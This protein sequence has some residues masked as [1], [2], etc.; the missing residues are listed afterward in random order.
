MTSEHT[1]E[2]EQD[3]VQV[4]WQHPRHDLEQPILLVWP[5][6]LRENWAVEVLDDDRAK[7]VAREILVEVVDEDGNR[8]IEKHTE[9]VDVCYDT[10][11]QYVEKALV[12]YDGNY[13][14]VDSVLNEVDSEATEIPDDPTV[15]L[16]T[17]FSERKRNNA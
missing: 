14:P 5:N 10:I 3:Q 13:G 16:D 15:T 9:A 4:Q 1:S 6:P 17:Y 8:E 11:P 2:V 7:V 12:N